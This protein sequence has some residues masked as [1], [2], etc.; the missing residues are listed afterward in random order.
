MQC[1]QNFGG[2]K[3]P[4]CP[5]LGCTPGTA[6]D[7]IMSSALEAYGH[8]SKEQPD[9]FRENAD[10]LPAVA[11]KRSA[12]LKVTVRNSRSA[13]RELQAAK[14]TV[15][16]LTRLSV[17]RYWKTWAHAYNNA[18]TAVTFTDFTMEYG[19][20]PAQFRSKCPLYLQLTEH[21]WFTALRNWNVG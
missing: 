10:L 15:Q 20:P 13:H 14:R 1:L 17:S 18:Q 5:P 16:R 4:K 7:V 9:W 3:C 21:S 11:A 8:Q 2:V 12:R 6:R 19:K